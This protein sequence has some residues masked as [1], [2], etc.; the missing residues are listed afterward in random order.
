MFGRRMQIPID[1]AAMEEETQPRGAMVSHFVVRLREQARL[2]HQVLRERNLPALHSESPRSYPLTKLPIFEPNQPVWYKKPVKRRDRQKLDCPWIPALIE[3][4]LHQSL[5][6]YVVRLPGGGKVLSHVKWLGNRQ[7][8]VES[9]R[10]QSLEAA[11][12]AERIGVGS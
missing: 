1:L 9:K 10:R 5:V 12:E 4:R 6:T 7:V 2:L 3:K 8:Q 11:E